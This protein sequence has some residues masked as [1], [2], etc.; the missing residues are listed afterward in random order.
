MTNRHEPDFEEN[1]AGAGGKDMTDMN[2]ILK[3]I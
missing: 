3:R 2:L 1:L